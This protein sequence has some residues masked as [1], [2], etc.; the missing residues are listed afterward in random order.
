MAYIDAGKYKAVAVSDGTLM[1]A[2]TGAVYVSATLRILDEGP[3]HNKE[4][5]WSGFFG[6]D[7]QAAFTKKALTTLGWAGSA[8][9]NIADLSGIEGTEVAIEVEINK[10]GYSQVKYINDLKGGGKKERI[11]LAQDEVLAYAQKL[12]GK[13]TTETAEQEDINF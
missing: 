10:R 1:K 11:A 3:A 9:D 4:I 5:D 7:K 2:S 13:G 12:K 6:T 8:E